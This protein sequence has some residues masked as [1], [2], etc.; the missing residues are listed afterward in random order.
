MLRKTLRCG[1]LG[2]QFG[3]S[4]QPRQSFV[5]RRS[6]RETGPG[7]SHINLDRVMAHLRPPAMSALGSALGCK[8]DSFDLYQNNGYSLSGK[9]GLTSQQ[10]ETVHG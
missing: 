4:G 1:V 3:F 9:G 10:E 7:L 6:V 2:Q 8:A 5:Q